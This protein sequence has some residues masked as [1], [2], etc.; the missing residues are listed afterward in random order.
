MLFGP[1]STHHELNLILF[2]TFALRIFFWAL[3]FP[4]SL[5][6]RLSF[7][8]RLTH[9]VLCILCA[10]AWATTVR[11]S[12]CR[13]VSHLFV[14]ASVA[15]SVIWTLF[16]LFLCAVS[17]SFRPM[18]CM[19]ATSQRRSTVRN[20]PILIRGPRMRL[21]L[22]QLSRRRGA[23]WLCVCV[24]AVA[25][26]CSSHQTFETPWEIKSCDYRINTMWVISCVLHVWLMWMDA[27]SIIRTMCSRAPL[28]L[29][30][31]SNIHGMRQLRSH[32]MM[33]SNGAW[34]PH[35]RSY[36]HYSQMYTCVT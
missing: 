32:M 28:S 34:V 29:C 10:I 2:T 18:V 12:F 20:I 3:Y 9:W 15:V 8:G 1:M 23:T 17:I 14:S 31:P 5:L 4:L 33:S 16:F 19:W 6:Q 24:R 27:V 30:T 7:L 25:V 26:T 36:L 11:I 21:E 22:N 35:S 13:S